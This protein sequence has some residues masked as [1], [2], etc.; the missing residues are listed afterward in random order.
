M[1]KRLI[2]TIFLPVFLFFLPGSVFAQTSQYTNMTISPTESYQTVTGFGA[3]LAYYENWLTAHP[4]KAEIYDA[5]FK[6][7]SLDILRVR[8]AYGYQHFCNHFLWY[9]AYTSRIQHP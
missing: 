9:S 2:P 8:N 7:L 5:I 3:S 1:I 6:E 4:K